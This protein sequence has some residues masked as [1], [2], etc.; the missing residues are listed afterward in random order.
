MNKQIEEMAE[1][2]EPYID[3]AWAKDCF[4]DCDS[5]A[6]TLYAKGYRKASEV[7][8]EIFA[9]IEKIEKRLR[10]RQNECDKEAEKAG[11]DLEMRREYEGLGEG[12]GIC[13]K[14]L[15]ELKKKYE[16]QE[17]EN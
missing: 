4:P 1:A 5:L 2:I 10:K 11:W 6:E 7:A 8:R 13:L 12:I 3:N 15:A 17:D 14:L 9:E 16:V